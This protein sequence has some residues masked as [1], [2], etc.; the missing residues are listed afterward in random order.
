M[1]KK[2]RGDIDSGLF[3]PTEPEPEEQE[4]AQQEEARAEL[5]RATYYISQRL[6]DEIHRRAVALGISDSQ[7][8]W[9]MLLDAVKRYDAGEID[10]EPYLIPSTSPAYRHNIDPDVLE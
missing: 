2:R 4:P 10:P 8:A 6:K 1:A 5:I 9:Y 3:S 7:L